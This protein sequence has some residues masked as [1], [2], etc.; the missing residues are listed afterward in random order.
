MRA[1]R[2]ASVGTMRT[3]TRTLKTPWVYSLVLAWLDG[4]SSARVDGGSAGRLVVRI[5]TFSLTPYCLKVFALPKV[6]FLLLVV[7]DEPRLLHCA[8][9]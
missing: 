7:V 8:V 5:V 1:W 2:S 9:Q 3:R 4:A 6:P